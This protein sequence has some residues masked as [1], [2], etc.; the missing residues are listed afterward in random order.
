VQKI[1][2][3]WR[4]KKLPGVWKLITDNDNVIS[5]DQHNEEVGALEDKI[6]ELESEVQDLRVRLNNWRNHGC[7]L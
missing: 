6:Q 2:E 7:E 3:A 1:M 5:M 4:I